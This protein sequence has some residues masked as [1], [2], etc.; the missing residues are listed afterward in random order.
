MNNPYDLTDYLAGTDQDPATLTEEQ[1]Q[2]FRN[3]MWR[4]QSINDTYEP[5]SIFK[6]VTAAAALEKGVVSLQDR[7]SCPGF[8]MVEDRRI[9]CHKVQGH[10]S[11]TFVAG[12]REFLQ[13]GIH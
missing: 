13:S 9:R 10:G 4:N 5:G 1:K 2:D 11:E 7:F 8:R 12:H 6:I 3:Q